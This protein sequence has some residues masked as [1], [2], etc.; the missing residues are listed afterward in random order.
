MLIRMQYGVRTG[1]VIDMTPHEA[2][3]MLS[4]GRATLPDAVPVVSV[5]VA[6]RE[7][8]GMPTHKRRAAR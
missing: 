1:E 7:D 4:D 3:A 8:R 5:R 2:H 6:A